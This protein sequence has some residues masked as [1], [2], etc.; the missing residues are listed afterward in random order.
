MSVKCL[1]PGIREA[2]IIFQILIEFNDFQVHSCFIHQTII[3]ICI[4]LAE[5]LLT[6]LNLGYYQRITNKFI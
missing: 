6:N 3:V 1:V 4:M 5:E 2:E